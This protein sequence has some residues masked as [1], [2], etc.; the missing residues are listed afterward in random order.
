MKLCWEPR[1]DR[2]RFVEPTPELLPEFLAIAEIKTWEKACAAVLEFARKWGPLYLCFEHT[3]PVWHALDTRNVPFGGS[4]APLCPPRRLEDGRFVEWVWGWH[5]YALRA[6]DAVHASALVRAGKAKPTN[7]RERH[8]VEMLLVKPE[9]NAVATQVQVWL[10]DGGGFDVQPAWTSGDGVPVWRAEVHT[11]VAALAV[12][13]MNC[14]RGSPGVGVCTHC[15]R[16]FE[17]RQGNQR[18]CGQPACQTERKRVEKAR[19]RL[20]Q[21]ISAAPNPEYTI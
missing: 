4:V 5:L 9:P 18:Y 16:L 6:R 7:I 10:Q 1:R 20:R 14:L 17:T 12:A 21:A 19:A 13:L 11:L 3:R 2:S 8:T 15:I